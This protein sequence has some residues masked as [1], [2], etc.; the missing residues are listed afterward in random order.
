MIEQRL[1]NFEAKLAFIEN[2]VSELDSVIQENRAKIEELEQ[3]IRSLRD[4]IGTGI[5]DAD[6]VEPPPHY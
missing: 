4:Q 6:G 2:H 3:V 5:E 1:V